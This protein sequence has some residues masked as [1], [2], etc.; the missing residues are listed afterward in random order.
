MRRDNDS[1]PSR[2]APQLAFHP[3]LVRKLVTMHLEQQQQQQEQQP[4]KD[5]K[6]AAA[7]LPTLTAEAADAVGELLKLFVLE[8]R[9]RAS[10]QAEIEQEV[11][12][13]TTTSSQDVD[14]DNNKKVQV[15]A[16]H[17]TRIAAE[18]LMDFS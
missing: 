1:N 3:A 8:A 17:V 4:V 2:T 9:N 15:R 10:L 13:T 5:A 16:D 11:T 14:D 12:A 6:S 18:M 7:T